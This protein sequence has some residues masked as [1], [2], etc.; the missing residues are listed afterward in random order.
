MRKLILLVFFTV[1]SIF[2]NAQNGDQILIAAASDL[3]F[4]LDSIVTAFKKDYPDARV[5]VTYGSSGKLFE[6]ISHSAP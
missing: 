1:A 5:D 3:K 2:S 4:A 6:Q